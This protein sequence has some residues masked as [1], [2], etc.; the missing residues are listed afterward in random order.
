MHRKTVAVMTFTKI[1]KIAKFAKIAKILLKIF[2][3]EWQIYPEK[4]LSFTKPF[5]CGIKIRRPIQ[6]KIF[7]TV[8]PISGLSPY[9]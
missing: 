2:A 1:T 6:N 3:Q 4:F 8:K 9:P 7:Y 5:A